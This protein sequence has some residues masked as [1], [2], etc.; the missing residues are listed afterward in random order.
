LVKRDYAIFVVNQNGNQ[1]LSVA[2]VQK[3]LNFVPGAK[4]VKVLGQSFEVQI[5]VKM[6]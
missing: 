4:K 2:F 1:T 6:F 5:R 3:L